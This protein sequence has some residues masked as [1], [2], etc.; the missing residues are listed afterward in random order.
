MAATGS[1]PR[2]QRPR[3]RASTKRWSRSFSRPSVAAEDAKER[4]RR[5]IADGKTL[6]V[7]GTA[8]D[9]AAKQRRQVTAPAWAVMFPGV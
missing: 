6:G 5:D 3:A 2:R 1:P 8:S 4:I 9:D 7:T